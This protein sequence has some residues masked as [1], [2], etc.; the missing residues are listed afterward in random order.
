[1]SELV[2]QV[3][4]LRGTDSLLGGTDRMLGGTDEC[5]CAI[6]VDGYVMGS[7]TDGRYGGVLRMIMVGS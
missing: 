5:A 4:V 2:E 3:D 1:M 7:I 6:G